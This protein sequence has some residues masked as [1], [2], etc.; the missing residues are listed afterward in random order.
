MSSS[1]TVIVGQVGDGFA[2]IAHYCKGTVYIIIFR[3]LKENDDTA[4]IREDL[5]LNFVHINFFNALSSYKTIKNLKKDILDKYGG[6]DVLI[7]TCTYNFEAD[8]NFTDEYKANTLVNFNCLSIMKVCEILC[9]ALKSGHSTVIYC[10]LKYDYLSAIPDIN[11]KK[12]IQDNKLTS[13]Q[14]TVWL[15]QYLEATKQNSHKA[16]WGN[17]PYAVSKAGF[18]ALKNIYKRKFQARGILN[19]LTYFT[20]LHL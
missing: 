19:L 10:A 2:P 13:H 16:I 7:N 20:I 14:L 18:V 5:N 1:V 6:I 17:I 3:P 9:S 11:I 4:L 12:T 15:N 8:A